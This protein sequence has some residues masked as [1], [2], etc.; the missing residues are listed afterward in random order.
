MN[1]SI[2]EDSG[3]V[4]QPSDVALAVRDDPR[5]G[6]RYIIHMKYGEWEISIVLYAIPYLWSLHSSLSC[7]CCRLFKGYF[8]ACAY[9]GKED[10]E[11]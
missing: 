5:R 4:R 1:K 7:P 2:E 11:N 3:A 6:T 9:K 10:E 8:C